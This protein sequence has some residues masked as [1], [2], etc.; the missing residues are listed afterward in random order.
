MRL[1]E[2]DD[3]IQAL[4]AQR[5]DQALRYSVLPWRSRCNRPVADTHCLN[6]RGKNTPI[7]SIIVTNQIRRRRSPRERLRNLPGKPFSRGALCHLEPQQ[8]PAAM[9]H[10]Q[11]GEQAL[12]GR[13]R[14]HAHIDCC[15]RLGVDAQKGLPAL[16]RRLSASRHVL[17]NCR[18]G[19]LET[20]HQQFA[21][22]PRRTPQ[23]VLPAHPPD[24]IAQF[25]IDLG[26]P[27]PLPRFP[28]PISLETP[29]MPSQ[30]GL[31][32]NHQSRTKQ[33]RPKLGHP[34]KHRAITAAQSKTRWCPPQCNIELM[35][36]KQILGFKP[37]PRLEQGDDEHSECMQD[38]KHRC[39]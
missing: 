6:P 37:A 39:Q 13:R 26:P 28:A 38:R 7:S 23:R 36:E 27:C 31:R 9:T 11:K 3:L 12:E 32:S 29:A 4:A 5:A 8:L 22:D 33:A 14:N 25:T 2:D 34:Y 19:H 15:N 16:G 20:Q 24:Q 10:N 35:T 30:N 21:M 17:R 1:T 18:L